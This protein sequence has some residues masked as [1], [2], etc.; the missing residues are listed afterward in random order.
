MHL[1]AIDLKDFYACPLGLVVRSL[2]WPRIRARWSE[3][4]GVRIFGLGFATPYL[5]RLQG[6]GLGLG[7]LMPAE[8]GAV[9]WPEQGP[10]VERAG[11]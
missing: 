7:A 5:A 11:R 2:L 1:D 9:P 4:K 10:V 3:L 6:R 8:L